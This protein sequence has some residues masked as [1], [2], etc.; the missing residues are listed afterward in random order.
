MAEKELDRKIL[1]PDG[2]IVINKD[3]KII[4]FNEAACRIT[5]LS[6]NEVISKNSS[7]LFDDS[8]DKN[9]IISQALASAEIISNISLLI[10]CQSGKKLTVTASITPVE[11]PSQGTIGIILVFRDTQETLFLYNALDEKNKE[12]LEEKNKLETIFNSLLE[13]TFTINTEWE[14]TSFNQSAESITGYSVA[15]AIGKKYWKVFPSEEGNEDPQLKAFIA[16]HQK[17][18]LRETNIIRKDGSR[19]LVR[20]NSA[21]LMNTAG[22]K[23]GR[24][25]TFEDISL[26]KNLSDH[27]EERFHFKNIIGRSKAMLK[28]FDMMENVITTDS[29]VLVTGQSGTGKEIIARA[30]H[31]NSE[32]K[33]E[34]FIAVNC[35]SFAETL[36]ESELFGHEKGAFTGAIKSKPGRFELAGNGTLFLDEVGD[37]PLPIQVKLLRVIENRQFERVGGTKSL[38]LN[39]RIICATHRNLETE[40]EQ[41]NFREDLYYRINV[42]NI[43]LPPLYERKDD[44]PTLVN[45]F[46]QKFNTKFNKEINHISSD[47]LKVITHYKWPGNIRELENVIEHAFVV[48]RDE[49][50]ETE[51]L[52]EKLQ[53]LFERLV[54]N[55]VSSNTKSLLE[56]AEKQ[57]VEET[58]ERFNGNRT[59]TADALGIEKTTLWRKMKK[60]KLL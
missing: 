19:T 38:N 15:E 52:P 49:T 46:I 50:I 13:G 23:I 36:L 35:T 40:I 39:A 54:N 25:V 7:F 16:E 20:I 29:T 30:I 22:E 14:I 60:F 26:M 45:Y 12:I 31:L 3:H 24:V 47:A 43:H 34:P 1:A 27:I 28:V 44:I 17:E 9:S 11:Q 42:I 56:L 59:E 33:T 5:G 2:M 55:N 4:V 53:N 21:P 18:L 41:G 37:I 57:I 48:C 51:H 8:T 6:E 10:N 32:R 58:L